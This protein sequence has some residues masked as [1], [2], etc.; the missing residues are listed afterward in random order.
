MK[1]FSLLAAIMIFSLSAF[2]QQKEIIDKIVAKVGN[3]LVLLSDIEE[4]YDLI[5]KERGTLPEGFRCNLM[6]N[7]L[8]KSLLLTHAK[9]D[10]IEVS[11]EEVDAQL[12]AR[13]EQ[14]LAYMNNDLTQFEE[15]YGQTVSEVREQFREDLQGQLLVQ[16]MRSTIVADIAI[17]PE[18]VKQFFASI[19]KDSLP[20]FNSEVEIGEIVMTPKVNAEEKTRARE[21]LEELIK[22]I[23][24][25]GEDFA[26]LAE[27]YSD[28]PG[29]GRIGGDLGW[30]RRGTFVPE[31]E[32]AAYN[33]EKD[34]LSGVVETEFGFH[35]IQM[36]ERRGNSIHTR[37]ILIRPVITEAD[38]ELTRAKMDTIRNLLLTDSISFSRAVKRYSDENIQSFNNDGNMVNPKTGNT[39]FEIADLEPEIYFTIDTMQVNGISLPIR[40][41]N[42]GGEIQYRLVK[43]KSRTAPHKANLETDYSKIKAAALESKTNIHVS[44]WIQTKIDGTYIMVDPAYKSCPNL[45]A[46]LK[47]DSAMIKP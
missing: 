37:H 11:D 38:L 14:I 25:G 43:L 18:E 34:E 41:R 5:E 45:Q 47:K 10:S 28:D 31:F 39:F 16:R 7:L 44:N 4:Q 33:L 26:K 32:A 6:D 24:E 30:Q 35:L 42:Q 22:R 12:S 3:E 13:I 21:K 40:F 2:A 46:W 9:L 8:A 19:P 1:K 20:Y 36:L 29:S 27:V 23:T 15:Y 17:T